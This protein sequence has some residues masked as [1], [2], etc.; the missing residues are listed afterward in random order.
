MKFFIYSFM[1]IAGAV[2]VIAASVV[3]K[4]DNSMSPLTKANLEALSILE[5]GNFC[6]SPYDVPNRYLEAKSETVSVKCTKSGHITVGGNSFSGDYKKGQTYSVVYEVKNCS[7]E[8]DGACC[9]QSEVGVTI[10]QK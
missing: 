3:K 2:I 6:P 5:G 9:P 8:Q 10:V 1:A 4:F 7:G